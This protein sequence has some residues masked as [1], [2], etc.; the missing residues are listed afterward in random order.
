MIGFRVTL[1]ND[2]KL[3]SIAKNGKFLIVK[4]GADYENN[5]K[6][7]HYHGICYEEVTRQTLRNWIIKEIET[8]YYETKWDGVEFVIDKKRSKGNKMFAINTI[9]D[10]E[11]FERYVCKGLKDMPPNIIVN[12]AEVDTTAR[13]GAYWR[14]NES[15]S[16][17]VKREK[18]QSYKELFKSYVNNKYSCNDDTRVRVTLSNLIEDYRLF[19]LENQC[20][21]TPRSSG[22]TMFLGLLSKL[23]NDAFE[24]SRWQQY[25]GNAIRYS[26]FFS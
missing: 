26:E 4:E 13:Y 3:R 18:S 25:Y 5:C 1:D 20:D 11:G 14:V 9:N 19:C 16:R 24:E 12:S 7:D 22:E 23:N 8:D 15:L 6:K 17:K 2:E 21:P 10:P